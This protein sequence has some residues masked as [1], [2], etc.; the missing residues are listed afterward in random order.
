MRVA[1]I[2]DEVPALEHLELLLG[3]IAPDCTVVARLRT[4]RQLREW[5]AGAPGR[6]D[7]IVADIQLGDGL[8]LDALGDSEWSVPVVFA[9]AHDHYMAD[10][11]RGNGI[12]YVLKP[13]GEAELAA[14]LRKVRSLEQHFVGSLRALAQR[15]EPLA[16]LRLVGRRGLDWVG[17]DAADI[18]WIRVRHSTTTATT[19]DGATV[20]LEQPLNKL[21][22]MLQ[23]RGFFRVNR[24][25]LVSLA[26]V[27]RVRS[28]GRGRLA[29]LLEPPADEPVEVPQTHAAQFRTW[30]GM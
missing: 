3:R 22:E 19:A 16:P 21:S 28:V 13:V 26:A 11:L 5:L 10:A 15:L 6:C 14:A 7:L 24:W 4:V 2:E 17:V 9:T 30:F 12:A 25:Y 8:S 27:V 29:V 18:R 20:M 1:L 23:P